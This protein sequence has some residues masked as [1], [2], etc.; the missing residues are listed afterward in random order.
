MVVFYPGVED[1]LRTGIRADIFLHCYATYC[2][3]DTLGA[4]FYPDTFKDAADAILKTINATQKDINL[5]K[6]KLFY[7]FLVLLL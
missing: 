1:Y 4:S 6:C 7:I 5:S 3:F 2:G